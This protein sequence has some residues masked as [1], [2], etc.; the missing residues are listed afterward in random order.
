MEQR[1]VNKA[2]KT[3][4]SKI[5]ITWDLSDIPYDFAK[6]DDGSLAIFGCGCSSFKADGRTIK[7]S[8]DLVVGKDKVSKIFHLFF[9]DGEPLMIKNS[10]GVMAKNFE[11]K[12]YI[13]LAFNLNIED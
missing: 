6:K 2:V 7:G 13:P 1:T 11:G 12:V 4:D 3:G 8:Y 9:D 10:K 5:P